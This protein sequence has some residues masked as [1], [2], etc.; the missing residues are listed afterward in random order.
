MRFARA[1]GPRHSRR[2]ENEPV[3]SPR[4][5]LS[6]AE[7]SLA[8]SAGTTSALVSFHKVTF[9]D[10]CHFKLNQNGTV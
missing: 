4:E 6:S 2:T 7:Q 8:A 5:N 3:T 1:A 10:N 9:C